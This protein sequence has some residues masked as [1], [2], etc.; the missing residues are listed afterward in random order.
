MSAAAQLRVQL[1]L[2]GPQPG[3]RPGNLRGFTGK[4]QRF[5]WC[6]E[7]HPQGYRARVGGPGKGRLNGPGVA[8]WGEEQGRNTR[9]ERQERIPDFKKLVFYRTVENSNVSPMNKKAATQSG[10]GQLLELA[11]FF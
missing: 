9:K 11:C 6:C 5:V 4:M 7:H 2:T 1:W 10:R 8:S 3:V